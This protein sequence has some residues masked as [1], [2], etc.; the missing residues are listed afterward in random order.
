MYHKGHNIDQFFKCKGIYGGF[1]RSDCLVKKSKIEVFQG[2][3]QSFVENI[4]IK[5]F[6]RG[7]GFFLIKFKTQVDLIEG[8]GGFSRFYRDTDI[9]K[10]F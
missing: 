3:Y 4:Q 9:E 2:F 1:N 8:R 6:I 10:K 7:R 5:G